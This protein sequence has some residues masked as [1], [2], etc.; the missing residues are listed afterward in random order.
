M[1]LSVYLGTNTPLDTSVEAVKGGLGIEQ[2]KWTPPPLKRNHKYVYY[3]G[4]KGHLPELECSCLL[5]EYV[6][7]AEPGPTIRSDDLYPDDAPCP[8]QTLRRFCELATTGGQFA[9]I[10][11]DD[12]GGQ[13]ID[14]SEEDYGSDGLVRLQHIARGHLLFAEASWGIPWRIMHVVNA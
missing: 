12:S 3:L 11:C 1:C 13:E 14:C 4:R 2:A 6:N 8:F 9:T 7:W 10:V 5:A